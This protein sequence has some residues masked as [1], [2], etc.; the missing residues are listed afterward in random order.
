VTILADLADYQ[1]CVDVDPVCPFGHGTPLNV[2]AFDLGTGAVRHQDQPG[3]L[4]DT[5]VFGRDLR[6][7]PSWT[8]SLFTDETDP[9]AA[10]EQLDVLA[11]V[12]DND[13][14]LTSG[15]VVALR[16]TVAGR[17]RRVYGRPRRWTPQPD[18]LQRGKAHITCDFQLSEY[19][20][21]YDDTEQAIPTIP[22]APTQITGTYFTFPL[23]FPLVMA[24]APVVYTEQAVVVGTQRTWLTPRMTG[25][26]ANPWVQIGTQRY[27]LQGSIPAGQTV[28][29]SGRPWE[30]GIYNETTGTWGG[31]TLDPRSRL[32]QLRLPP[33]TYPITYSGLDAT[34]SSVCSVRWNPA[35]RAL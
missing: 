9:A 24:T 22:I 28:R 35:Y 15:D 32:S 18:Q 29:L 20:T 17:T 33:G 6:T 7:P 8:W 26:V 11:Q 27:A 13:V 3:G 30:A 14:R 16:Y 12:W 10:L 1:F 2:T 23:V 4:S 25:P 5:N 31:L 19:E 34:G 21:Y